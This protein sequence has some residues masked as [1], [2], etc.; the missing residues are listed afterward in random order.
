MTE[1]DTTK[2]LWIILNQMP[3][4]G[5]PPYEGTYARSARYVPQ[6][7]LLAEGNKSVTRLHGKDVQ[8]N[9]VLSDALM[10][11][12]TKSSTNSKGTTRA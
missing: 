7:E 4:E 12:H 11:M 8:E 3:C 10:D 6:L 2:M 5:I 1:R 9:I